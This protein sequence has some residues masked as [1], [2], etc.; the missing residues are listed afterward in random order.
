[1]MSFS[2]FMGIIKISFLAHVVVIHENIV[3][4]YPN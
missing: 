2:S 1:M 3:L 4:T